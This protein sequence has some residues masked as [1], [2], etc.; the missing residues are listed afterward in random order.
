MFGMKDTM[1]AQV[2]SGCSFLLW[3]VLR[4]GKRSDRYKGAGV[5]AHRY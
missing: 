1:W 3:A 2:G 4:V 5:E